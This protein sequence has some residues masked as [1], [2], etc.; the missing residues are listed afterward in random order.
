MWK[1]L[2]KYATAFFETHKN[3]KIGFIIGFIV[4]ISILIF[5]FLNTFF[6]FICG[7]TGL[8]IGSKFD[9]SDDLI[10]ETLRKLN[11]ILPE[12]FQRW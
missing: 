2:K 5:G 3:R 10:D 4:G 11:R 6:V 9:S 1:D 7:L 12:R 8:Y